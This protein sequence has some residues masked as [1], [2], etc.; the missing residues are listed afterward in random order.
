V[1]TLAHTVQVSYN[2]AVN[3]C[4]RAGNW[5]AALD[6][7][8]RMKDDQVSA[9]SARFSVCCLVRCMCVQAPLLP[10]VLTLRRVTAGGLMGASS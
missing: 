6:M 7:L 2:A 3:A 9:R 4:A 1:H 10:G 5:R 8:G